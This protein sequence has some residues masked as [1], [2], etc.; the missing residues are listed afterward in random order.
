MSGRPRVCAAGIAVALTVGAGLC[1]FSGC[2]PREPERDVGE[3]SGRDSGV[4]AGE[5]AD[6]GAARP[7]D[8]IREIPR[9]GN[10]RFDGDLS[11]E[12]RLADPRAGDWESEALSA[13]AGEQLRSLGQWLALPG[14][15][16]R[17][18]VEAW[19][20]PG[21][22]GDR[23]GG[24]GLEEVY[25]AEPLVVRRG[26][27]LPCEGAPGLEQL[28]EA[29]ASLSP[30]ETG[31]SIER[32]PHFKIIQAEVEGEFFM[33]RVLFEL[34]EVFATGRRQ[35][36]AIWACRW[37]PGET[38][39]PLTLCELRVMTR[40]EIEA[41][42]RSGPLFVDCTEEAL[43]GNACFRE[44]LVDGIDHWRAQVDWRFGLEVTGPHGLAVGDVNGDGLDDFYF[45]EAGGLPNRLFVQEPGGRFTEAAA[46]AGLDFLEPSHSAL[47]IDLDGDADDDLVFASGRYLLFF[48]NL[49]G[50]RFERRYLHQSDSVAR[51]LAAADY[52]L[53]GDLD[54]Y[55][56]G[57]FSRSGD[58][59]GLGRPLPYHDAENGV[60][61]YLLR[62]E[63]GWAWKDVTAETGLEQN[64]RRFSYAAAWED[65]DGDGDPDLYV[66]ND[67][68][69]NNLYRND[70]GTFVD[71]AASAGVEDISAGMSVSWGDY[72]GD[73]RPDLYVGNMFSSAGNRIAYQRNYRAGDA[74]DVL[75]WHR[76][77]A[78]GNT[79]FRNRGDGSFEDAGIEAGASVGRW[80][81]SSNFVDLNG[82]G[83][84]DLYVANGMVTGRSDPADL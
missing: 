44:Q 82:D 50:L 26:A 52:D 1:L 43:G 16:T 66:A 7:E 30:A 11:A 21:F 61:S 29:G 59:V 36:N 24:A 76:R 8:G 49:G 15:E 46:R 56:C 64:N 74:G 47:L 10:A 18:S 58:S 60:R 55:V 35:H 54:L 40:E 5:Q 9:L 69:R 68:G 25:R 6:D 71:V 70:G 45:C 77:H 20:D 62:N 3:E 67:F 41:L 32:D 14:P 75:G 4:T 33:T 53:D 79:L 38:G 39:D 51:S 31:G 17:A 13:Q 83:R 42:G 34:E 19:I 27:G 48:E 84:D 80:A 72:D 78:R 63:G 2:S 57:Y 37:R 12:L 65:Y 28:R 73:G 81:W 22:T 23:L